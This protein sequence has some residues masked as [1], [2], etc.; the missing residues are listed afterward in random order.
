M[1]LILYIGHH[2]VG[3]TSLQAF[4]AQNAHK[5]LQAGILYPAVDPRGLTHMLRQSI[6][7][8][9]KPAFLPPYLREP[10]SALAYR[11]IH[12]VCRRPVPPQFEDMPPLD[13]MIATLQTQL[14]RLAPEAVIMCSEVFSNF[15]EVDPG[16]IDRLLALFPKVSEMQVY[17]VLRRP[18]DYLV[19]W[20][21]QR[22]KVGE[23]LAPLDRALGEYFPTVHFDYSLVVAPWLEKCKDAEITLRDY[24]SV[25]ETGNSVKDF[26]AHSM[27]TFPAGLTPPPRINKSLPLAVMEIM[28]LGNHSL[29]IASRERLREFLMSCGSRID[30]PANRNIEMLGEAQR[31]QMLHRFQPIH[32]YLNTVAKTQSFF[33]RIESMIIPRPLPYADAAA[34]ALAQ[35]TPA[36]LAELRDAKA[37]AFL[38]T[39]RDKTIRGK[40]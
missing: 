6:G 36:V 5:L 18:D 33:P 4:L 1:K 16:L 12:E 34:Q 19:S 39:L 28:R 23:A 37:R 40:A 10:H 11:M 22:L 21:G 29:P 35:M 32:A 17:A 2:K 31:A 7:L 24:G 9:D 8:T 20:H 25:L 30:L 3:S 38:E 15:G 13:Q 14:K 26:R 27:V